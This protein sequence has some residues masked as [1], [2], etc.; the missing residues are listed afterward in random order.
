MNSALEP[1]WASAS[2]IKGWFACPRRQ[3]LETFVETP[4]MRAGTE[5]HA[6][7]E[8]MYQRGALTLEN[9]V[10]AS[11]ESA[12]IVAKA[13]AAGLLP[14]PDLVVSCEGTNIPEEHRITAY[15]RKLF[16]VLIHEGPAGRPWGL[17]GAA[18]LVYLDPEDE[19]RLCILDWKGR[20]QDDG[21]I[22]AS[23]YALAY[24]K[25]FP[26]FARYEFRQVSLTLSWPADKYEFVAE[27]L[28]KAAEF[29]GE[30][31]YRMTDDR[32]FEPRENKWCSSC[33]V[34]GDCPVYLKAIAQPVVENLP[35]VKTYQLPT[36]FGDLLALKE[37]AANY[38]KIAEALKDRCQEALLAQVEAGAVKHEGAVYTKSYG[39][40]GYA[41]K[42]G[43]LAGVLEAIQQNVGDPAAFL[44]LDT[45]RAREA[46]KKASQKT[47]DNAMR[48][49]IIGLL[50]D[51]FEAKKYPKIAK[52]NG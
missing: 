43:R 13:V 28:P 2:R 44:V 16:K 42:D 26:G 6:I 35:A 48:T 21:E 3:K 15:G 40:S 5:R 45:P 50:D 38:E 9:L 1:I 39:V 46:L 47:V 20:S 24:A 25:M 7:I 23:C 19:D 30:L 34:N 29:I 12:A 32:T 41:V 51:A 37:K 36:V 49:R 17:R 4:A 22:Q 52:K 8:K 31:V 10:G 11:D 18:D 33:S 27:D 14:E